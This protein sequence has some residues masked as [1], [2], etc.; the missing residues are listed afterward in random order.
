MCQNWGSVQALAWSR[1]LASN[2]KLFASH[3][4]DWKRLKMANVFAWDQQ[5]LELGTPTTAF[6]VIVSDVELSSPSGMMSFFNYF[7]AP[8][9]LAR[10]STW[11]NWGWGWR[12]SGIPG[13]AFS[14]C[15]ASLLEDKSRS[16]RLVKLYGQES[17]TCTLSQCLEAASLKMKGLL[18][19][20]L[21]TTRLPSELEYIWKSNHL[22]C[23][24]IDYVVGL[25]WAPMPPHPKHILSYIDIQMYGKCTRDSSAC[26]GLHLPQSTCIAKI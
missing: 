4:S 3:H 20:C 21:L 12:K 24:C 11:N 14:W 26:S 9:T 23:C 6:T 22:L 1:K 17:A 15:V 2:T 19:S 18:Y 8:W 7:F 5:L 10:H 16:L 13:M 25:V